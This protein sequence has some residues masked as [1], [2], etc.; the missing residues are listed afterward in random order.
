MD[1]GLFRDPRG[2]A[3]WAMIALAVFVLSDLL[4]AAGDVFTIFAVDAYRRG[5][6]DASLLSRVDA[7]SGI[8]AVALLISYLL[9]LALVGHWFFR[10]NKNAHAVDATGW[11]T[12]SPGWSVGWFAIPFANLVMPFRGL[13]QTL[14]VSTD[15]DAPED[16]PVPLIMRLWWLC[17]IAMGVLGQ[18]SFRLSL[19]A[20]TLEEIAN[21]SV[22]NLAAL[23]F[24]FIGVAALLWLIRHVTG[25]QHRLATERELHAAA[26]ELG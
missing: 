2:A 20:N 8:G 12:I 19:R 3:R 24:D 15:L 16:V 18:L 11:M 7:F 25:L 13:R 5:Q 17:W 26:G 1:E 14:Q 9:T 23:P 10:T 21:V 4:S 22:L 6:E